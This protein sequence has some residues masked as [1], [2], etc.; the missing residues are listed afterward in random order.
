[1]IGHVSP[2]A[3]PIARQ[4]SCPR[5][6]P[7]SLALADLAG[8]GGC[9]SAYLNLF[10]CLNQNT[11]KLVFLYAR[12]SPGRCGPACDAATSLMQAVRWIH[13]P[14]S[15]PFSTASGRRSSA[16]RILSRPSIRF[17]DPRSARRSGLGSGADHRLPHPR[18]FR[19]YQRRARG[20]SCTASTALTA[21]WPPTCRAIHI[22]AS[23]GA[24]AGRSSSLPASTDC[25]SPGAWDACGRRARPCHQD[26]APARLHR[27]RGP[28]PSH[29]DPAQPPRS[30]P[31]AHPPRLPRHTG[32]DPQP[33]RR[34]Q[35]EQLGVLGFVLNAIVLWNTI[36][37]GAAA[38]H[39]RAEGIDVG[40]QD[41]VRLSPL[42]P[43]TST[44]SAA[45]PS[46][47]PTPSPTASS[48]RS[49]R[50]LPQPTPRGLMT[51]YTVPF[52]GTV[53]LGGGLV[54][55]GAVVGVEAVAGL[56][57]DLELGRLAGRLADELRAR[58]RPRGCP[59]PCHPRDRGRGLELAREV[60]RVHGV[61]RVGVAPPG[62]AGLEVGAVL[63]IEPDDPA[64]P[65]EAG[66]AEP[67]VVAL[68]FRLGSGGGGVE[69]LH[70]LLVRH[71]G[72]HLGDVLVDVGHGRI[73]PSR[74]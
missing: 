52:A 40:P 67:G 7:T 6:P 19:R 5:Y 1:M 16:V 44:S 17:A 37:I 23:S 32:R 21:A 34:G 64:A 14:T 26:P 68:P 61:E 72:D 55:G 41:V 74:A 35:E 53:L 2:G 9:P 29:P 27:R 65:A 28:A 51:Q 12:R 66:D 8:H 48:G 24:A 22:C 47:C 54:V 39:L 46:P 73:S 71:L 42:M 58:P 36:H 45:M 50:P 60:D 18:S 70:D 4:R 33:H 59:G 20:I 25:P 38:E 69:V 56:R 43:S 31:S 15:A 30:P 63:G 57:A 11:G 3:N 10:D 62:D 13:A 49:G